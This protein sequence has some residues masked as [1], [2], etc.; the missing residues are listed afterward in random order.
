[1]KKN[2]VALVMIVLFIVIVGLFIVTLLFDLRISIKNV[3]K[4]S[5]TVSSTVINQPTQ[6]ESV[7]EITGTTNSGTL[8]TEP[9][10]EATV[11]SLYEFDLGDVLRCLVLIISGILAVL[12]LAISIYFLFLGIFF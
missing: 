5:E 8:A 6:P 1:M 10:T 9:F 7:T 11:K 3:P 4:V 2:K 12:C